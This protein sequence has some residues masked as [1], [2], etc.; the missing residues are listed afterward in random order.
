MKRK[1][2]PLTLNVKGIGYILHHAVTQDE[3]AVALN[4]HEI[5]FINFGDIFINE[6]KYRK[7]V[8]EN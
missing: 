3:S 5:S 7:I 1:N 4:H 2:R 8:I 6:K